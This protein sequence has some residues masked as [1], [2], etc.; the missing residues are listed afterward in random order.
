MVD[1][2]L[3]LY[4]ITDERLTLEN[5][6]VEKVRQAIEGGATAIQYRAK[7]KSSKQI[8]REATALKKLCREYGV[9]LII[10]DRV[11]IVAGIDADGVHVGQDD[12]P[13]EVVRRIIGNS[14]IVG[15]ST[16]TLEQVVEANTLPVDYIGFGSVFPTTTKKDATLSGIEMLKEAVKLS[17]QP[18][19]AIGGINADNIEKVLQTGCKNIAVVSAVF[20]ANNPLK[21]AQILKQ[22]LLKGRR[23]RA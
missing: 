3:R 22:K 17:I 20:S 5:G 6:L 19:V 11:D 10:N 14:K 4:V 21:A 8:Y 7:N 1:I 18:V 23:W 12:L 2:D 13:V 15:L 9:P 16:K